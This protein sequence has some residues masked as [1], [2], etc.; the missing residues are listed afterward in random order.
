M[1][2]VSRQGAEESPTIILLH[3]GVINR[4]MWGPVVDILADLYDCISIDLPAHGELMD[5]EFSM[6]RGVDRVI[7]ILDHLEIEKSALIGLSL[8]GYIAQ[9]TVASHSRRVSGLVL[10]GATINYTGWDGISTR[11]YGFVFPLVARPA[12]KAFRK[13]MT[14]DLGHKLADEILSGGLS[15]KGGA[16]SLRRIPGVDYAEAMA[17]F[18]GPIVIAN[19]ERDTPNREGESRFLE[20]FPNAESVVITDAGHA[21]ALQQPGSFSNAIRQL[22]S[23]TA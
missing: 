3:G 14:E 1:K 8:G 16:Q 12:M 10:S 17:D 21:C 22:M 4:H 20:L 5:E 7:E 9:A 6:D 2:G 15:A 11:F 13:Q 18:S 23:V 19:G